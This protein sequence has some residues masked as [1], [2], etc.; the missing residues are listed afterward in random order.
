MIKILTSTEVQQIITVIKQKKRK[1][2]PVSAVIKAFD[3]LKVGQGFKTNKKK[4]LQCRIR[5]YKDR[6]KISAINLGRN[7]FLIVRKS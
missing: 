4:S 5:A 1:G 3:S 2:R 7:S 6:K